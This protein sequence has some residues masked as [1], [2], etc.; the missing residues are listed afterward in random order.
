[1]LAGIDLAPP[2]AHR[3]GI[4]AFLAISDASVTPD[5]AVMRTQR[6]PICCE[7]GGILRIGARLRLGIDLR[8]RTLAGG[9][10]RRDI[11]I[12]SRDVG[13]VHIFLGA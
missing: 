8:N 7:I 3:I 9:C 10:L 12:G 5:L 6:V 13:A 1:M 4:G 11:L 2:V